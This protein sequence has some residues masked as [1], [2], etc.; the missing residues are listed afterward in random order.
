ML[1]PRA[2]PN[3]LMVAVDTGPFARVS[4]KK[5]LFPVSFS[6]RKAMVFPALRSIAVSVVA[7]YPVC[8]TGSP[9]PSSVFHRD[10]RKHP[11]IGVVRIAVV[12][13]DCDRPIVFFHDRLAVE[14]GSKIYH[15][16]ES[17]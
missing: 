6:L 10:R 5:V 1:S 11:V 8:Q 14:V 7:V 17:V 9:L 2:A 15:N 4:I 13:V 16:L 12:R 3:F